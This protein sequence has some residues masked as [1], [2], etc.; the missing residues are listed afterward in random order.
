MSTLFRHR[1][2]GAASVFACSA[3]AFCYAANYQEK[4]KMEHRIAV[5]KMKTLCVGRFL[6]DVPET[7]LVSYRSATV[8]GYEISSWI[9]TDE[10]FLSRN[11][12]QE[13][14][15]KSEKNDKGGTSLEQIREIENDHL[16]GRL[17]VF[18]RRWQASFNLGVREESQV[19]AVR[20]FVRSRDVT[21]S[22]Y[23]KYQY[24]SDVPN[25][26][27]LIS[28]LRW[29]GGDGIPTQA[30][31]CF[32]LGL[33]V[34]PLPVDISEFTAIFVGLKEH[35]DLSIA[36]STFS[37]ATQYKPLSQRE[38]EN[39]IKQE[40]WS[41]FHSLREGPRALAGV[42]GDEVLERVDEPNGSVLHGFM[43]ESLSKQYDPARPLMIL[44]LDTGHGQQ[45]RPVNSSLSDAEALALWD[46]ISSSLRRHH[47]L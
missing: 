47:P 4:K 3:L 2:W 16:H 13:A 18:N 14:Q 22:F 41:R 29:R 25:L 1:F 45:G 10:A 9:E 33:L 39:S 8:E 35:P 7:A 20:A 28:Q 31:F 24:D 12:A 42:M 37:G 27:K 46:K 32:E 15:L 17:F 21:Y 44:E 5:M 11:I 38:A 36:L 6:I 43:W 26:E 23:S 40:Y 19:I 34:E 30:G